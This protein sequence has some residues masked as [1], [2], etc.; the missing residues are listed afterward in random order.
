MYQ[1]QCT[2]T[3]LVSKREEM[4]CTCFSLRAHFHLQSL[5]RCCGREGWSVGAH[6]SLL[7]QAPRPGSAALKTN[8]GNK[9]SFKNFVTFVQILE[10]NEQIRNCNLIGLFKY[11]R[12]CM[13]LLLCGISDAMT[14]KSPCTDVVHAH[15]CSHSPDKTNLTLS[16]KL[17]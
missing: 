9:C 3:T 15:T 13:I 8:A 10:L 6:S 2:N 4:L 16:P 7:P 11:R 14:C 17:A 1:G 5:G 12:V